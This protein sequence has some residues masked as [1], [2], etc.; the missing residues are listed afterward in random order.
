MLSI[1]AAILVLSASSSA[2][3]PKGIS[4]LAWNLVQP[5][6]NKLIPHF[7]SKSGYKIN[8]TWVAGP[9]SRERVATGDIFDAAI[10]A[11]PIGEVLASGQVVISSVKTLSGL[12]L[13]VTV[14][15][16]APKPDISSF[17]AVKQALLNAKSVAYVDPNR[18]T[19]GI[20]AWATVQRLGLVEQL[21]GKTVLGTGGPN[22]QELAAKGVAEINL[23]PF[24]NDALV[25]GVERV[26]ALP[27]DVSTPSPIVGAIGIHAKDPAGAKT[28]LDFLSSAE[29]NAVYKELNMETV[30]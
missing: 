15:Q 10:M 5:A 3:V 18:G 26:G 22:A 21:R 28:L 12:K 14:R 11:G 23:G 19:I 2:Q 27:R 13:S 1:A 16:G 9:A 4:V 25:P 29:A 30:P 20:N 6:L 17:D 7:E 24:F 8:F